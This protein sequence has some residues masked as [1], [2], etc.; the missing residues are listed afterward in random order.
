MEY[1]LLLQHIALRFKGCYIY[2]DAINVLQHD[3]T[4][5]VEHWLKIHKLSQEMSFLFYV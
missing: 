1:L 3:G 4:L 5:V 2:I